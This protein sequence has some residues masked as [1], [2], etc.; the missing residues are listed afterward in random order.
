M[1]EPIT[2]EEFDKRMSE[3]IKEGGTEDRHMDADHLMMDLLTALG[4]GEGIKKFQE[5]TKWYA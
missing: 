4:Y 5:M 3:I 2:P 1:N